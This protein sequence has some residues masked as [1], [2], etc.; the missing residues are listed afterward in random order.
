MENDWKKRLGTVYSTNENYNYEY[1]KEDEQNTPLPGQQKLIVSLDKK[2]R[3]G[4]AVTLIA[5]FKGS[6]DELKELGSEL[7][8]RCGVG[9]TVKEQEI[10]LQ[11][12]HRDKTI[13]ILTDLGYKV[14][15]SGG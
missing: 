8:N 1:E 14:K 4:K 12:D 6:S 7:K 9:G 3:K 15:R 11:G 2:N 13:K 5:G 10:L